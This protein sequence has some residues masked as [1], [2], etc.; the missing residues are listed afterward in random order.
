MTEYLQRHITYKN[1]PR[2]PKLYYLMIHLAN[3]TVLSRSNESKK[4]QTWHLKCIKN[5]RRVK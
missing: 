5:V 1:H 3:G 4:N 2:L